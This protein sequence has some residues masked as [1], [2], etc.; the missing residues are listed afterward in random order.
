MNSREMKAEMKLHDDTQ[1]KLAEV[2]RIQVSGVSARIN[3]KID[4][5]ASEI[6]KIRDRYTLSNDRLCSIFFTESAS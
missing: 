4:F 2:L 6:E 3:G 5:R 1:E